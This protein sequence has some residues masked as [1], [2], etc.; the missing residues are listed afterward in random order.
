MKRISMNTDK[1]QWKEPK[2]TTLISEEGGGTNILSKQ[3][4]HLQYKA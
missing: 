3:A 1:A 4:H 2:S